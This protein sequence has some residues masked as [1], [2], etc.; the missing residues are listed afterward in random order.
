[1]REGKIVDGYI[2]TV[3][4]REYLKEA[5][6][7]CPRIPPQRPMYKRGRRNGVPPAAQAVK[8]NEGTV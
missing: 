3:A 1:M 8:T 5:L 4:A 7:E 2:S 6:G